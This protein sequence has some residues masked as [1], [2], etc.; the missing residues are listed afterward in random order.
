[1]GLVIEIQD[2]DFKLLLEPGGI[3]K[4]IYENEIS[5]NNTLTIGP[6]FSISYTLPSG[7]NGY[8]SIL[9]TVNSGVTV[10]ITFGSEWFIGNSSPGVITGPEEFI[11]LDTTENYTGEDV[12]L[13]SL[14]EWQTAWERE[15][16]QDNRFPAVFLPLVTSL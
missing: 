11:F 5:L 12:H 1:V 3:D 4:F 2:V 6:T 7:V 8:T 14:G 15:H 9:A 10:T 13:H 16:Q